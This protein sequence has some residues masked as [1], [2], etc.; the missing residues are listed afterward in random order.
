MDT[1]I[2][3]A[4]NFPAFRLLQKTSKFDPGA[5]CLGH[6]QTLP[7]TVFLK[8]F[9]LLRDPQTSQVLHKLGDKKILLCLIFL[10]A[11]SSKSI[12]TFQGEHLIL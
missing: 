1:D 5:F 6:L 8:V 7:G 3:I 12:L 10:A 11:H 4:F 9:A 2:H